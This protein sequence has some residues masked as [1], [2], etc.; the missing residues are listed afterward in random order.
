MIM[1][2]LHRR[3][4]MAPTNFAEQF[5]SADSEL[6][7]QLT[8]DPYSFDFL[9]LTDRAAEQRHRA[10][11]RGTARGVPPRARRGFAFVAQRY[12]FEVDGDD[13]VIDLLLFNYVQNR[14]VI[15]ELKKGRFRPDYA[16]QLGF[17][18]A[19][20]DDKLRDP[21]RHEAHLPDQ[22][23]ALGVARCQRKW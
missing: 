13:F 12:L 7:Q 15:F 8:M 5:P 10:R 21:D 17:Y 14:F 3:V 16:G 1:G 22:Q 18:V 19:W 2:Q 9:A 6:T 4:G 20:A 23:A 11:P